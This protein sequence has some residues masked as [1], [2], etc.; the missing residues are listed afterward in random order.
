MNSTE[1]KAVLAS[2]EA[3]Y[4]STLDEQDVHR[5]RIAVM[6]DAGNSGYLDKLPLMKW[7]GIAKAMIDERS[8]PCHQDRDSYLGRES[9]QYPRR[10]QLDQIEDN[11]IRFSTYHLGEVVDHCERIKAVAKFC[12]VLEAS[13]DDKY[14]NLL[15]NIWEKQSIVSILADEQKEVGNQDREQSMREIAEATE[16]LFDIAVK[17]RELY[18]IL[19]KSEEKAEIP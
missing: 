13:P 5:D 4:Q 14:A 9:V 7:R 2:L 15:F 12:E 18:K 10:I 8:P 17:I 6:K 3:A 19:N 16:E 11:E 1:K